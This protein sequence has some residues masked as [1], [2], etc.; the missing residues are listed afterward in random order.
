MNLSF[1]L[2]QAVTVGP[3][4]ALRK[5]LRKLRH[6]VIRRSP[7][8]PHHH[9][10]T[11]LQSASPFAWQSQVALPSLERLHDYAKEYRLIADGAAKQ[12]LWIA[13]EGLLHCTH[14]ASP[15]GIDGVRFDSSPPAVP[16]AATTEFIASIINAGN[17]D[18]KSTL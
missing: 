14:H 4:I 9:T 15:P 13:G 12:L 1:S 7:A 2:Y 17:V 8:S 18:R 10:F 16:F 3:R 5:L 6:S 11:A